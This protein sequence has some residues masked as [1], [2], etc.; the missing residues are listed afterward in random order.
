M[1]TNTRN[2]LSRR[3]LLAS[4]AAL[5]ASS[6]LPA[7][8]LGMPQEGPDT[9]KLTM[10][11]AGPPQDAEMRKVKQIGINVVDIPDMPP[12][13]WTAELLRG[14]MDKMK[15]Q[16]LSLGIVMTPWF[17]KDHMEPHWLKIVHGLP[18]RDVEIN[19]FKDCLQAAGKAGLPV[20]EYNFFP[21][22]ANEGYHPSPGRGG[23][24]MLTFDYETM[25]NLPPL[26][27]EGAVTYDQVWENYTHFLKEVV[28][29][30]EKSGVRLSVHPNDPPPPISRGSGQILNSLKD[31]KRMIETVDS[32]ASGLT[33]DCGVTREL[34]EDP[35]AVC[36]YFG[37]RDRINHIHFRNVN[38]FK[39]REHY[40]E[41]FNDEGDNDMYAVMREIVRQKY[42]RLIMPEHPRELDNDKGL[43]N[44][45]YTG[46]VYNVG[47]ARAMLQTALMQEHGK[48]W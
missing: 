40:V 29:V 28:P 35:I 8:A 43:K 45:G 39:P 44:G 14:W 48:T 37:S 26:P 3:G 36:K 9:P 11:I 17:D 10:Y 21:H 16:G 12:I 38:L 34:G 27:D 20:V 23:S 24:G 7:N 2:S 18:G 46:W 6:A 33:W 47:Y 5:A 31:W 1:I 13:P 30:A 25:K 15:T 4:G 32:K 19:K 22:R 42:K 41:V